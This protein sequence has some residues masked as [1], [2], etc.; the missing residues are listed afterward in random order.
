MQSTRRPG[1]SGRS[2][3]EAGRS[4]GR[5]GADPVGDRVQERDLWPPAPAVSSPSAILLLGPR[6]VDGELARLR[7]RRTSRRGC[8]RPSRS[9]SRRPRQ[10]R[11]DERARR[12]RRARVRVVHCTLTT[13]S[14]A[15]CDRLERS[16][17]CGIARRIGDRLARGP[18]RRPGGVP[19]GDV[20]GARGGDPVADD[21]RDAALAGRPRGGTRP[22][23]DGARAPDR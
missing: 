7:R 18:R 1:R 14:L 8:R 9:R 23:C 22:R 15:A 2:A 10:Q 16:R 6:V 5:V 20:A 12:D 11:A 17:R 3:D 4:R 21:D 19:R 13:A